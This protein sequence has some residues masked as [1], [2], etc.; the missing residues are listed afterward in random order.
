M[1]KRNGIKFTRK[2][3]EDLDLAAEHFLIAQKELDIGKEIIDRA[4]VRELRLK[5]NGEK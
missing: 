4:V 3:L 5:R 1:S 2:I